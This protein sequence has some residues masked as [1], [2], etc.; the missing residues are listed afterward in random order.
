MA[1]L[2]KSCFSFVIG[3]GDVEAV[4][5]IFRIL[6]VQNV[7]Y[8]IGNGVDDSFD[9]ENRAGRGFINTGRF[10]KKKKLD[11]GEVR[12]GRQRKKF[13]PF[14]YLVIL[15]PVNK[16]DSPEIFF[17]CNGQSLQCFLFQNSGNNF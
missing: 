2:R 5:L 3:V 17:M 7:F 15:I 6:G 8:V 16:N 4:L 12:W 1:I 9:I 14:Y 10:K 11:V 13:S